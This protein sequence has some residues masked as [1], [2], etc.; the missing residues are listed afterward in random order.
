[1]LLHGLLISL[2]Y[3]IPALPLWS[4]GPQ[5]VPDKDHAPSDTIGPLKGT[6]FNIVLMLRPCEGGERTS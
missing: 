1:M 5:N 4:A 2:L 6:A 3:L